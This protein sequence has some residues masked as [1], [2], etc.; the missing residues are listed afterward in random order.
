L[1]RISLL[2]ASAI[3]LFAQVD[4]GRVLPADQ[5]VH[6]LVFGDFGSGN[7]H[8]KDTAKAMAQRHAESKFDLGITVGDNF[9][10]CGVRSVNDP[11][12]TTRWENFYTPLGIPIYASLGNHDY[13]HPSVICPQHRGSPDAE[14]AYT[15]H[16]K[17]WRMPA[18][19]YTFAAGPVRFFALDTEGWSKAQYEWLKG[20]LAASA[21]EPGI[22]WR[23]V[24]GHHPVLSSGHHAN[25]RRI[26]PLREQLGPL[27]QS[28]HVDLYICGHDHSLERL[29]WN[30]TDLLIAG[31]GGAHLRFDS[32][33]KPESR[34]SAVKFGFLDVLITADKVSA[35]FYD[36]NLK[37]LD[38]QPLVRN[39][40]YL[41]ASVPRKEGENGP[42]RGSVN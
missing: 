41:P 29:T 40:E 20:A 27:F 28:E 19:Y 31:G 8:Q 42:V 15:E 6:L 12:W 33:P 3:S 7:Q 24:Y 9:Y 39:Y 32:H 10:R 34:F 21:N 26:G 1:Y 4:A 14:V 38:E 23:I 36:T 35:Q 16:S 5:P 18:R 30:G 2:L 25:E 17:S 22:R 37:P 13:G 11:K